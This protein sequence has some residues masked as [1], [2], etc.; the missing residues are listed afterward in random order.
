MIKD[1]NV[2]SETINHIEE[3][4]NTKLMGLGLKRTFYEFDPP[5][6]GK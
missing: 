5:R 4:K 2:R 6:Q 3:N 1:L